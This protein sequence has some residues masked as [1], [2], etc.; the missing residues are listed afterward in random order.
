M[1]MVRPTEQCAVSKSY[2]ISGIENVLTKS[3]NYTG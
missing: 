3:L 1:S 2:L